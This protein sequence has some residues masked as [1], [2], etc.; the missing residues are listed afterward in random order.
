MALPT[1]THCTTATVQVLV[2]SRWSKDVIINVASCHVKLH[3]SSV[4]VSLLREQICQN[5]VALEG[6]T[7]P[8]KIKSVLKWW[9][10]CVSMVIA[11]TVSKILIMQITNKVE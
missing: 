8:S 2:A 9:S 5:L 11:K 3:V 6:Q 4:Y 7:K 1:P 10:K